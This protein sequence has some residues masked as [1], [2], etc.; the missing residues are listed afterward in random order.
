MKKISFDVVDF[1]NKIEEIE[2]IYTNKFKAYDEIVWLCKSALSLLRGEV[3]NRGFSSTDEEINFFKVV[4]QS[5]LSNLIYYSE[6]Y[7]FE[8]C[9]PRGG[10]GKQKKY[11]QKWINK[12]NRFF[13]INREF[14]QYYDLEKNHLDQYFFTRKHVHKQSPMR[15]K[16]YFEDPLF[17][18]SHDTLLGQLKASHFLIDYLTN[19]Q[20]KLNDNPIK[21][22]NNLR[23]TSSKVS[24]TE[25]VYA[26][27]HSNSI[28]NGAADIKQIANAFQSVF[29]FDLGDY[30]RTYSEI[31]G[32]QK[33]RVK[34]LEE[35]SIA[36]INHMDN[37][38][39]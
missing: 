11:I 34:F 9:F 27:Y 5:P 33:S 13:L 3:M 28:N 1:E 4:K 21:I 39:A 30:Y 31:R 10:K 2:H 22:N 36:M 25:L 18:T 35:L 26:L 14:I 6:I 38:N 23:W 29:N 24:L 19:K 16:P 12:V 7:F 20:Q 17:N 8:T 37:Q 15:F 32:R